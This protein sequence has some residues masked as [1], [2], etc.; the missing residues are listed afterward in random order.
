MK[1]FS[2]QKGAFTSTPPKIRP[3][4]EECTPL[5]PLGS[6]KFRTP[7]ALADH[8]K[9][10]VIENRNERWHQVL[11]PELLSDAR[12][13]LS[14]KKTTGPIFNNLST[15]YCRHLSTR[16]ASACDGRTEHA[17]VLKVESLEGNTFSAK[18]QVVKAWISKERLVIVASSLVHGS[19]QR[20]YV[21]LTGY[22]SDPRQSRASFSR[23]EKARI[24]D[25]QRIRD[26]YIIDI[27]DDGAPK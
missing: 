20:P 22:R 16:L 6:L 24:I 2:A 15:E 11:Q 19:K 12:D 3:L 10:H 18:A 27:H 23:H 8:T 5:E 17:H 26:E 9:R 21:L 4:L 7:Y 1:T 13:E 25:Q 14:D